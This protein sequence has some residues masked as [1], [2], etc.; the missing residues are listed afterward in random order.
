M[1]PSTV[2]Q[3]SQVHLRDHTQP[4]NGGH[5]HKLRALIIRPTYTR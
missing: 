4:P 2:R 5:S 1:G 3:E